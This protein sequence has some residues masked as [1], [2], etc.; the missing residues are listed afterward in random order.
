MA[1]PGSGG[2]I[3]VVNDLIKLHGDQGTKTTARLAI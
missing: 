1:H 3:Y 2:A